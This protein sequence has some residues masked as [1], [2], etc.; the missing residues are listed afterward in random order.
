MSEKIDALVRAR[1]GLKMI[2]DA[3]DDILQTLAPPSIHKYDIEK[4]KW[5]DAEG[6]NG[7]YQRSSDVNSI[8]FKELLKDLVLHDDKMTI[9]Q[10]FVWK[11]EDDA[12]I[13]RKPKR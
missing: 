5:V 2:A 6:P 12:K 7:K 13:G 1:D 10:Y 3:V 9:G 11:F 4:V 8:D